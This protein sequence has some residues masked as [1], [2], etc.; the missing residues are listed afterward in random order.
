MD[1]PSSGEEGKR[2]T[3]ISSEPWFISAAA[4][5]PLPFFLCVLHEGAAQ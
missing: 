5:P 3:W 1:S 2:G 4:P